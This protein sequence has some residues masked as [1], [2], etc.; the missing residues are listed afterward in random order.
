MT[1]SSIDLSKRDLTLDIARVFCVL[2]VVVIHLLMVGV[3]FGSDGQLLVSRPLGDQPWFAA[4]TWIGQIMPLFFVVGGF[5][6]LTAW[7][8]TRRRG[9]TAADFVRTRVLRLAQPVLPLF[10]FYVI[11][12]GGARLI[13]ID[14]ALLDTVVV[15]AGSP[16]WFLA[17]YG[18][19]QALVPTMA[20]LHARSP[21]GTLAVLLVGAVVA[22]AL[23]YSSGIDAV[24][25]ANLFFVW[26][27]VQQLGFWYADGWFDRRRWWQLV[28]IAAV[29]YASLFPL[30]GIGPYS[31]DM[32]TNLNPPTLPLVALAL[33]QACIL[34]LLRPA[35]AA[36]MNTHATRA[37]VFVVGSR[38][39]TIY[40]WH[41]PVII[42]LSGA[43][44]L[45][46]G[47][48]PTPAGP[49]WWWSRTIV[50]VLVMAALF[51]LSFLVGRWEKPRE[52][53]ATPP[54]RIVALAAV[55][56]FV[57]AFCVMQFFL[58]LPF[59]VL[60][61]VFYGTAVLLLGRWPGGAARQSAAG[62]PTIPASNPSSPSNPSTPSNVSS[63]GTAPR[64]S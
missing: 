36:L 16:L 60:G 14:P 30:T 24:G 49:V 53:G 42:L 11:V 43:A 8:S 39:M 6:S 58:D 13:G 7:R 57:P 51:G 32:L 40:L 52:V 50:F 34:R 17:A 46:P 33:G 22:D 48:S 9:G 47:A 37:F 18:L 45:I 35:L 23:R 19:C 41:L 25:L 64:A 27:L 55:L 4:V 20:G 56:T 3:G 10:V 54:G 5:A 61:A 26:L 31:D 2:L 21:R 38:L 59:A 15:G 44:L 62:R 1:T 29:A 63:A 12:I 28:A